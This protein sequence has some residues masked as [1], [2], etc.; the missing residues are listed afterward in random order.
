MPHEKS[1]TVEVVLHWLHDNSQAMRDFR[2]L[3]R[4][5]QER[6]VRDLLSLLAPRTGPDREA[7]KNILQDYS[8]LPTVGGTSPMTFRS[9]EEKMMT[10]AS[11]GRLLTR[12]GVERIWQQHDHQYPSSDEWRK[13][14]KD[15]LW[16]YIERGEDVRPTWCEHIER[17]KNGFGE[18][19]FWMKGKSP[20]IP[21]EW[22]QCP[23][24]AAPRPTEP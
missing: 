15:A 16:R 21:E 19:R 12:E 23:I 24:C 20:C 14:L 6:L 1:M 7:L 8:L 2:T 17:T 4:D 9:L 10:W 5:V 13:A 3:E 18:E 22:K 11:A